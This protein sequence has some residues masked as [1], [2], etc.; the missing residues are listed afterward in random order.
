MSETGAVALA[1]T[2]E[3]GRTGYCI[4]ATCNGHELL[5]PGPGWFY[6]EV[7][8]AMA[9]AVAWIFHHGYKDVTRYRFAFRKR[10]G[11]VARMELSVLG[12]PGVRAIVARDDFQ[13]TDAKVLRQSVLDRIL[14]WDP[15][16]L[17]RG[18]S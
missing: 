9:Y 8:T 18:D 3:L 7:E 13:F 16:P 10:R 15:N 14:R 12:A 1:D 4:T 11:Q 5:A 2:A 17:W 6:L